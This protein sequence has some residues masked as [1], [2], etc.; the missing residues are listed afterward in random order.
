MNDSLLTEFTSSRCPNWTCPACKS[1]S[2]A[3]KEGT[4][5]TEQTAESCKRVLEDDSIDIEDHQYVFSCLLKCE[6]AHCSGVVAVSGTGYLT[7]TPSEDRE[8]GA[9][10]YFEL[11]QATSFVPPIPAFDIPRNC[12]ES[13]SLPLTRSFSLCISTPG[14]AAS[15]I[16]ITLEEL[17]I[18]L[19]DTGTGPLDSKIKRLPAQYNE[20]R[21]PLMA[22][23]WLGNSGSHQLD[24]VSAYDVQDAYKIIEFVLNKIYAGSTESV[25]QLARR[26]N[27]NFGRSTDN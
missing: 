19:G 24:Q 8:R 23:K 9:Q 21:D 15:L 12:P 18:A 5:N 13:V 7:E 27:K 20:H 16:R 1:T 3:I 11:Y 22:I 25:S 4:F 26:M 2:L 6:R 14:S 17:M 10:P